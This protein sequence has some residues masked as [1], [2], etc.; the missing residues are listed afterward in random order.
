MPRSTGLPSSRNARRRRMISRLC[1]T[2][3]PKPKPGSTMMRSREIPARTARATASSRKSSTSATTSSYSGRSC[4][5]RG[6]P[7][8]CM[9]TT[10]QPCSATTRAMFSSNRS[11][12]MSLMTWAPAAKARRATSARY[13]STETGAATRPASS[14]TTGTTRAASSRGSTGSAPG[15]VDSPPTSMTSAPSCASSPPRATAASLPKKRPPSE[16]ESGVT[17]RMPIISVRRPKGRSFSRAGMSTSKA[18]ASSQRRAQR[19]GQ[20]HACRA[21]AGPAPR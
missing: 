4:M 8:M 10:G 2:V 21:C 13:V 12:E 17:L 20:L 18:P 6:V 7:F 9:R 1:S 3:L 15:L 14:S 19:L 16:K 5:S 11:A